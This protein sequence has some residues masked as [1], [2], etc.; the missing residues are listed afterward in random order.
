M[1][2][3]HARA[4][5]GEIKTLGDCRLCNARDARRTRNITLS[6]GARRRLIRRDSVY[7]TPP[8]PCLPRLFHFPSYIFKLLK[9]RHYHIPLIYRCLSPRGFLLVPT[10]A[11]FHSSRVPLPL[12]LRRPPVCFFRFILARYSLAPGS[13]ILINQDA[14]RKNSVLSF[15]HGGGSPR[16]QL[17][18]LSLL[19]C[20]YLLLI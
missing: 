1:R 13:F 4:R 11:L 14:P 6:R 2:A 19:S 17:H 3:V 9:L 5:P 16:T 20:L 10:R 18:F 7:H 8:D 15:T 12:P